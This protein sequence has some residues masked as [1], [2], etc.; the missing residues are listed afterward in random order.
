MM[1]AILKRTQACGLR[2]I[3]G[4]MMGVLCTHVQPSMAETGTTTGLPMY[5]SHSAHSETMHAGYATPMIMSE[6]THASHFAVSTV[7]TIPLAAR[8]ISGGMTSDETSNMLSPRRVIIH[9]DDADD[10]YGDDPL[11]PGYDPQN[12]G[13]PIG[14]IPWPLMLVLS[15]FVVFITARRNK[16][17][18]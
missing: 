10:G 15:M 3:W 4:I 13:A 8:N 1:R 12:P 5:H 7:S 9:D 11:R 2:I 14:D 6:Q 17:E 18:C 16:R